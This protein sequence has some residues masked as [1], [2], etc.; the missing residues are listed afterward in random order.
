[1]GAWERF[2]RG[3]TRLSLVLAACVASCSGSMDTRRHASATSCPAFAPSADLPPGTDPSERTPAYWQH[4]LRDQANLDAPL[5]SALARES[6]DDGLAHESHGFDLAAPLDVAAMT[7]RIE[8]RRLEVTDE[9]ERGGLFEASGE[10]VSEAALASAFTTIPPL[11]NASPVRVAVRGFV[12]HCT[13]R[14]APYYRSST[15]HR[16]DRNACSYVEPGE[17]IQVLA[18][19][20][21]GLTLVRSR[22]TFGFAQAPALGPDVDPQALAHVLRTARVRR[23]SF[24]RREVIDEAFQHMGRPYGWGGQDGGLDCSAFILDVL[25]AFGIRVPRHSADQASAGSFRVDIPETATR[26]ERLTMLDAA[27]RQGV[28]L[29]HFPGHVMLHL[30]RNEAG[31]PMAIHAFAEY[32]EPCAGADG[33]AH[34]TIRT[35]HGVDVTNYELGRYTSRRSYLERMTSLTVFGDA[36]PTGDVSPTPASKSARE[37]VCS[38]EDDSALHR[39]PRRPHANGPLR[40]LFTAEEPC[41]PLAVT[42]VGP[43]GRRVELPSEQVDGPPYA[44]IGRW[45]RAEAGTWTVYVTNA[46]GVVACEPITVE[47]ARARSLRAVT[48]APHAWNRDYESLW[49]LFVTKLF[50]YPYDDRTWPNLQSLLRDED[51]NLL[52]DHFTS[53]EERELDLEPDCADLPYTLRAYFAWKMGLPFAVRSCSSGRSGRPPSCSSPVSNLG[54]LEAHGRPTEDFQRFATSV[55]RAT[56]HSAGARTVPS[57]ANSDFYPIDLTRDALRPGVIYA[58]PYGHVMMV[59]RFIPQTASTYGLLTAADAQPDATIGRPRFWRGTFLFTP[60]TQLAGAGFKAFRPVVRAGRDSVRQASNDALR[61]THEFTRY[62]ASQYEGSADDFYDRVE[63]VIDPRPVDAEARLIALVDALHDSVRRRAVSVDNAERWTAD[64][65]SQL[66]AMPTGSDIFLTSGPWEDFSTPSRDLR[67]LIAFD[68]VLGFPATVSRRPAQFGLDASSL[69]SALVAIHARLEHEL[70]S[71]SF[72]YQDSSGQTVEVTLGV[73][74]GR[75]R[76]LEVAYNPNDCPEIRWGAS[77]SDPE[78][79]SCR[80]RAPDTQRR[81]M[82]EYRPWFARRERPAP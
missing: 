42:L 27:N 65:R 62:S 72:S 56:A 3:G 81:R 69:A 76:A 10:R 41:G 73:L 55:V 63:T 38:T 37:L 19:D 4:V 21:N 64:H 39:S 26:E 82:T 25:G 12:V 50:D 59:A 14:Q 71:R 9:I 58:D 6:L 15:D 52:I 18:S 80:R 77:P 33:V 46:T 11:A 24:T 70:S 8:H 66:I 22:Y 54:W 48:S 34:E 16:F 79:R 53:N 31:V 36:A 44:V 5:L 67:L 2:V 7:Q 23:S 61:S 78:M 40:M 49:S 51:H 43:D 32:V 60:N 20:A 68:T 57:D 74:R 28:V 35:A 17:P 75:L 13:P 29:V 1:M 45:A 47:P 30:G